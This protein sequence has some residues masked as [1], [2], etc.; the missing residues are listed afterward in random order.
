MKYLKYAVLCLLPILLASCDKTGASEALE[1]LTGGQAGTTLSA[2]KTAKGFLERRKVYDWTLEKK[3][4]PDSFTLEKGEHATVDYT[5]T[6][7]RRLVSDTTVAGVR[8][9]I[10]VTNGG[11]RTTEGLKLFDQ[12]QYKTGSGMFQPLPGATQTITPSEQLEPGEKKCYAYKIEFTPVKDATYRNTVKVTITNHSGHLGYAFGPN[13]KA[14]FSLPSYPT[15]IR[16]DATANLK[17][18][19]SCPAGFNCTRYPSE[20]TYTLTGSATISYSVKVTN[21]SAE[22]GKHVELKNTATLTERDSGQMRTA[23]AT[24]TISTGTCKPVVKQG[25]TPGY[26]KNHPN[27]WSKTGYMSSQTVG[28]VF[29]SAPTTLSSYT[30]LQ[31]LN[32]GGGSTLDEAKQNLLRAAVAALLNAAHPDV[33]YEL[34][35]AEVIALV[36]AALTSTD[37]STILALAAKLDGYNNKGCPLN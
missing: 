37:R 2:T 24:V 25:C 26:W 5:L 34:T 16:T 3:A 10:C 23:S 28:S 22:C 12:V 33:N 27:A 4:Y 7:T 8:G 14:G 35:E 20:N 15:V 9:E 13:P 21:V 17:D 32:F 29:T 19:L 18:V 36:N 11:S 30:L 6:A 31:A 1:T